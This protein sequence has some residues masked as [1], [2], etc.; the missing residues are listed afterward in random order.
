MHVFYIYFCYALVMTRVPLHELPECVRNV[1]ATLALDRQNSKAVIVALRGELGSGKTT[2]VQALAKQFGITKTVQSPTYVLMKKYQL[3]AG[4]NPMGQNR[5]FKTFIHI[6]AY[7]L[8]SPEE[9]NT[10]KPEEF[11]D[12]PSALV[13]VEWPERLEGVLR[14]PDLVINF[15]SEGASENERYIEM[16]K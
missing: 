5:R 1:T 13:L 4:R 3:P 12:D 10:L 15:S 9:F 14:K 11:L 8:N 2:F 6:D 7:R 16:E